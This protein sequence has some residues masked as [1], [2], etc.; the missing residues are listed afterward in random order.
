MLG[1]M[2]VHDVSKGSLGRV[3][4][5]LTMMGPAPLFLDGCNGGGSSGDDGPMEI[6]SVCGD[7]VAEGAEVCDDGNDD[8]RDGCTNEC[9]VATCGDGVVTTGESCDDGD[10]DDADSCTAACTSGPAAVVSVAAGEYHNCALSE[11]GVVRCWGAPDYGR[12]G[13]PGYSEHIG[14]DEVPADWDPVEVAD[15]V[16]ELVAGSDHNCALRQGGQLRCWGANDAGQLGYGN[17][18]HV[19]DDEAPAAAGDVPLPGAVVSVAAGVNHTCAAFDDGRV[20]C[21]GSNNAGKLGVGDESVYRIGLSETVVDA[22]LF[23]SLPGPA[24]EVVAGN[25]HSCARLGSGDVV[26]WGSNASGQLGYGTPDD[27]GD[28]EPADSL[29]PVPLGGAAIDIASGTQ[30]TCAVLEGGTVR[31]WGEGDSGR[32]GYGDTTDIGDRTT[33]AEVG[34]VAL[35]GEAVSVHAGR[36]FTCA[37]MATGSVYC[38][39]NDNYLGLPEVDDN[40]V[41]SDPA[42]IGAPVRS[43]A[44]GLTHSCAILDSAA[45]TCWGNNTGFVLGYPD[46][47]GSTTIKNPSS[48]GEVVVF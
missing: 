10:D 29:G 40:T 17:G 12:L 19:G 39:G 5:L 43:M 46:V 24:V 36:S 48:V 1:A 30:H 47:G 34:D 20:A 38:W 26:C 37:V 11:A 35:E 14:D 3:L 4:V 32:L 44:T 33:P 2:A 9:Q 8:P 18:D 27:I 16:V 25:E 7:G 13:Q 31:C 45:V 23:V 42:Q 6:L 22:G 21:W 15:D 28:D 41:P